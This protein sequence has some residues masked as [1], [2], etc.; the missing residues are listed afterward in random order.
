MNSLYF[1]RPFCMLHPHEHIVI[2]S[3]QVQQHRI[4]QHHGVRASGFEHE[5]LDNI[6]V[7]PDNLEE[8]A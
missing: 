5:L 1:D 7:V 8:P 2:Y 6:R 3:V 4:M